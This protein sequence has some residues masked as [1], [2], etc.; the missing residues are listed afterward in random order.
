[1]KSNFFARTVTCIVGIPAVFSLIWFLPQHNFIG[2][3]ILVFVLSALGSIEMSK[4]AF[5]KTES[6][7]LLGPFLTVLT[8]FQCLDVF[9]TDVVMIAELISIIAILGKEIGFG[10]Y[11]D[12][13]KG[14]SERTGKRL[15][16]LFY[17]S[18]FLSFIIKMLAL[19][20]MD[21]YSVM[22]FLV[23]VFSNDIFA[24]V[25]GMLFRKLSKTPQRGCVVKVSPKKTYAG[26]IGGTLSCIALSIICL[27]CSLSLR[28]SVGLTISMAANLGDLIE[29]VFKR[30]AGVKDSGKII[31]GRGGILDNIDSIL[32]A[33]PFF[34]MMYGL[35]AI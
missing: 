6:I 16:V 31:P 14:S 20:K 2:L 22:V 28:I 13:F 25:F 7:A 17:P 30:S 11:T 34:Y 29:S 33:A 35:M 27:R 8:Y 19:E 24:Y 18:F 12:D 26:F 10:A 23:L 3:S 5:G 32:V 15:L 21:S 9:T 1:M 4:M